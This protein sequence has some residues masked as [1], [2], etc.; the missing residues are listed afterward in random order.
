MYLKF[1]DEE[2]LKTWE[3]YYEAFQILEKKRVFLMDEPE[4][5][6]F[7]CHSKNTC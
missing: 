5:Q 1:K 6:E 3:N 7:R 2:T 4:I